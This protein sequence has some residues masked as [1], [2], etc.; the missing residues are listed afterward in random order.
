MALEDLKQQIV[1]LSAEARTLVQLLARME[2]EGRTLAQRPGAK[3]NWRWVEQAAA[4]VRA[5]TEELDKS[6]ALRDPRA[7]AYAAEQFVS[8][9]KYF[10]DTSLTWSRMESE[11]RKQV[12]QVATLAGKVAFSIN[13]FDSQNMKDVQAILG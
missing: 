12:S 6:I 11:V 3:V 13:P 10:E 8:L 7:V 2:D 5:Y 9:R 1:A 4:N